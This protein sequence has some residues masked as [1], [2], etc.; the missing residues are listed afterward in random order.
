MVNNQEISPI[1]DEIFLSSVQLYDNFR[2]GTDYNIYV[3]NF[4]LNP[5]SNN[6]QGTFNF[7]KVLHKDLRLSLVS[8]SKFTNNNYKP[9]ILLRTYSHSF[10]FLIIKDGL[11]GVVYKQ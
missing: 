10:N 3:Y 9:N 1:T 4:A 8:P 6:T 7:S 5:C 2:S 11:A